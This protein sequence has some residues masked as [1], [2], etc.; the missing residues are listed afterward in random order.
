MLLQQRA[1]AKVGG[2]ASCCKNDDA[3]YRALLA[4]K[5]ICDTSDFVAFFVDLC[6]AGLFDDLYSLR[7]SLYQ[8]FQAL[9]EGVCDGHAGEFGIVTTVCSW[10][11]MS[12]ERPSV[13]CRAFGEG[14]EREVDSDVPQT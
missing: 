8:L 4:A 7:V 13:C 12:T 10:L 14:G 5:I 11:G 9:H 6:N 1:V 2:I 3:V